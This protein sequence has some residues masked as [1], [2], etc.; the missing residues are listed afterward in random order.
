MNIFHI[1]D[2][3][4]ASNYDYL[5]SFN[6]FMA[7]IIRARIKDVRISIELLETFDDVILVCRHYFDYEG[8]R[9]LYDSIVEVFKKQE[10]YEKRVKELQENY[11]SFLKNDSS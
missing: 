11:A 2:S 5:N 9:Y 8:R 1:L 3:E 6:D 7:L 4:Q 10:V